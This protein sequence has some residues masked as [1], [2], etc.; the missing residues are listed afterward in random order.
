MDPSRRIRSGTRGT[1]GRGEGHDDT[2]VR[3]AGSSGPER[4]SSLDMSTLARAL[5]P[6]KGGGE[7]DEDDEDDEDREA[8]EDARDLMVA[9]AGLARM[10]G[11]LG[12]D[13]EALASTTAVCERRGRRENWARFKCV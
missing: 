5:S 4:T 9:A 10:Y 6:G 1:R 3:G 7:D 12:E 13:G 8:G 2:A 11:A